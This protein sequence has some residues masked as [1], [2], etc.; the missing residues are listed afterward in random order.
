MIILDDTKTRI[1]LAAIKA[2]RQ[3]GLEGVRI[4]NVS[5]LA[6]ISAGAIYRH[7]DSKDQ[8]LVECFTYVDKQ[9]A[10]IFERL[11][12]DPQIMLTD[13][14]EADRKSVV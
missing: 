8:L 5:E 14:M 2:V 6:E 3:Y 11:E 13:P 10:A 1:I 12:F 9:A 7:F 4:Q